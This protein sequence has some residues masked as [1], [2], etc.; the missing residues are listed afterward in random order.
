MDTNTTNWR[1]E[2]W[3]VEVEAWLRC[4]HCKSEDVWYN[5]AS[6]GAGTFQQFKCQEC[7]EDVFPHTP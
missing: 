7:G 1:A 4:P 2:D 5:T 6:H 3:R